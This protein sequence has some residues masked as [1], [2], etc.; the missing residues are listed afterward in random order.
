M[1]FVIGIFVTVL[2]EIFNTFLDVN[3][4]SLIIS[5]IIPLIL[6]ICFYLNLVKEKM[7]I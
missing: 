4:Y 2:S 1:I 7:E 3:T 5:L 6:L